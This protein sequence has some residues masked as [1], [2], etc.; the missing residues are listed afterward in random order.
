MYAYNESK[1][2][3]ET[4]T[5]HVNPTY[6][7]SDCKPENQSEDNEYFIPDKIGPPEWCKSQSDMAEQ[8]YDDVI[9]NKD[10]MEGFAD[11]PIYDCL[12]PTQKGN[13]THS[14]TNQLYLTSSDT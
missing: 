14:F 11:D 7:G 10:L 13:H 4:V 9:G 6:D 2:T 5:S 3:A 1:P 8:W 12:E